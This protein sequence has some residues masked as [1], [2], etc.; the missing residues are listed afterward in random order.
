MRSHYDGVAIMWE[1]RTN[2]VGF[3]LHGRSIALRV[4]QTREKAGYHN[5]ADVDRMNRE[6]LG[7]GC[8]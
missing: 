4:A 5:L 7:C 8:L 3:T 2:K 6:I 1:T